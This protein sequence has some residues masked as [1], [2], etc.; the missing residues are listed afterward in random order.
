MSAVTFIVV[1]DMGWW[2]CCDSTKM[3]GL[4]RRITRQSK[5]C[6]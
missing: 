3:G 2:T 5:K 6:P 4:L 1:I